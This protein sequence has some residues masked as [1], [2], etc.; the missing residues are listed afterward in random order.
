MATEIDLFK[1]FIKLKRET[2]VGNKNILLPIQKLQLSEINL[3][4]II[5]DPKRPLALVEDAAGKGYILKVGDP[6]GPS[7]HVKE[8][9]QDKIIIEERYV[10][11]FEGQKTRIV[12]LALP[13]KEAVLP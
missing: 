12:E 6:I 7:G 3:K 5:W 13:K 10:D 11:I 9:K 1:P 8:I 4:G 2:P